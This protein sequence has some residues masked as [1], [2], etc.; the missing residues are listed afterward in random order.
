MP[1]KTGDAAASGD[2]IEVVLPITSKNVYDPLVFEDMEPA[3][4]EPMELRSGGRRAGG[5]CPHLEFREEKVI[6]LIGL[7]EQGT[8]VL[9]YKLPA[10]T[11]GEFHAF[12]TTGFAKY[13]PEV[14][15]ISDE[16]R[17]EIVDRE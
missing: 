3:D 16:M 10:D 8:Y 15:A 14:R 2:Q 13:A 4:C 17:L 6:F 1:L 7:L 12:P 9:R 5:L 11:P